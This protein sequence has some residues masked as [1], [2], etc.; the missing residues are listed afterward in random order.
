MESQFIRR[1]FM[2]KRVLACTLAM[3]LA[4]QPVSAY[5]HSNEQSRQ[6]TIAKKLVK[7]AQRKANTGAIQ[8][9]VK[10]STLNIPLEKAGLYVKVQK[11]GNEEQIKNIDETVQILKEEN[12]VQT[13]SLLFDNLEA[14][15]YTVIV[16]DAK[17]ENG[18]TS[19]RFERYM[20]TLTVESDILN[21]IQ[22]VDTH[23]SNGIFEKAT[24]Q[25]GTIG[26]GDF[27]Q[28]DIIDE[29][30][31]EALIKAI[32][33]AEKGTKEAGD[34]IYDLNQDD[35][36]DLV[37]LQ[38]F[39]YSSGENL[40]STVEKTALLDASNVVVNGDNTKFLA[41][42]GTELSGDTLID[43]L[44]SSET[45]VQLQPK[46]EGVISEKNPVELDME[47]LS[48]VKTE[49]IT[50]S[51]PEDNAIAGG[52]IFVTV[53]GEENPIEL[54]IV[55]ET[56]SVKRLQSVKAQTKTAIVKED[57][58]IVINLGK[59]V[60]IKRVVIRV[61]ATTNPDA[62]LAEISQVTFVN[63]MES[64]IPQPE[65]D[66]PT[67]LKAT[68][69]HQQIQLSWEKQTNVMGYEIKI[70]EKGKPATA[71]IQSSTT[72]SYTIKSF[73]NGK[74]GKLE[75]GKQYEIRVRSVNGEWRSA[76]SD[77]IEVSPVVGQKPDKPEGVSI[78]S[79][80]GQLSISWK[81]MDD[82]DFYTLYYREAG[83]EQYKKI[84]SIVGTSYTLKDLKQLAT[85][86]IYLTG[87]NVIGTSDPSQMYKGKTVDE[88][89]PETTEY[90]L[91]NTSNGEGKPSNHI[92][93][94]TYIGGI[95]PTDKFAIVDNLYSTGWRVDDWTA[96]V[97][98]P[99]NKPPIVTFDQKYTMDHLILIPAADQ[100]SSYDTKYYQSKVAYIDDNGKEVVVPGEFYQSRDKNGKVYY[101]FWSDEP[102]TADKVK[103]G[104]DSYVRKITYN[105]LRFY[106][107]DDI[108]EKIEALFTDATMVTLKDTVTAEDI[109]SLKDYLNT[110]D[111]KSGDYHPKKNI[112]LK[113]LDEAE[114][115]LN[116][117][118]IKP[119]LK[120]NTKLT[121]A[122]DSAVKFSRSL[123]T[124]QP[125]G[126]IAR[127]GEEISITVGR[128]GKTIGDSSEVK[129]VI[130][131]YN[132][133]V[134]AWQRT[135]ISNLKVGNNT[136]KIS[137]IDN[138][139]KEQGGNLYIE[140]TGKDTSAEISVRVL[141]GQEVPVLDL[142]DI[143]DTEKRKDKIKTYVEQLEAYAKSIEEIHTKQHEGAVDSSYDFTYDP[144][145]CILQGTDIGTDYVMFSVPTV[146][147]LKGLDAQIT[148]EGKTVS[149]ETRA[150]ALERILTS[151]D[152]M[153]TLFY[154]HKGLSKDVAVG[155]KNRVPSNRL[156][157]RYMT[158]F[159]GAFMY[160]ASGHIGIGYDSVQGLFSLEEFKTTE[161]GQYVSGNLFGWGIAHEIGHV[162]NQGSYEV[163]EVTNNFYSQLAQSQDNNESY[164]MKYED[165]YKD[166]TSGTKGTKETNLTMYWQLHLAYD[167][168][169]NYMTY[170]TQK[171][172]FDHF[173]YARVDT[174]DRNPAQA[175]ADALAQNIVTKENQVKLTLNSDANNN[176]MRLASA[177]AK[178]NLSD[179]FEAWGLEPNEETKAYMSQYPK[180]TRK[181]QYID[182][183]SKAFRV[184]NQ[185][186]E[187]Q[188]AE[189][190]KA[191]TVKAEIENPD[192]ESRSEVK[193]KIT[194]DS[195]ATDEILGYEII[196]NG[197]TVGFVAASDGETVFVD[198]VQTVN[199]RV[200]NYEVIA[201]DRLLNTTQTA[202]LQPIKIKNENVF[203]D[204]TNWT[205]TTNMHSEQDTEVDKNDQHPDS[206]P[207]SG[208]GNLDQTEVKSAL[209]AII[210]DITTAESYVGTTQEENA[211]M[212][213]NFNE[214]ISI[215][216]VQ[217]RLKDGSDETNAL[218]EFKFYV[219]EDGL[220]WGE[221][222]K[223]GTLE[224]KDRIASTYFNKEDDDKLYVYDT[225]YLKIEAVGQQ[226]LSIAELDVLAPAGDNVEIDAI[227][228][229]KEDYMYAENAV[230]SGGAL[231]FT[232]EYK[233]NPAYNVVLLRDKDNQII[234]GEQIIL[235][236]TPVD[237]QLGNIESGRW[238][239][240]IDD[241]EYIEQLK[242]KEI[243][244]ELY[245][246]DDALT[247]AGERLVSDTFYVKVPEEL[248]EITLHSDLDNK[249]EPTE[250]EIISD[251]S[252][253]EDSSEE[254]DQQEESVEIEGQL[255]L[256]SQTQVE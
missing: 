88:S 19:S 106:E 144:E 181:I 222:I 207:V 187:A 30:D 205:V 198:P 184:A 43:A 70:Q 20:Q 171:E 41:E 7:T 199:N 23:V 132:A 107:H 158:M 182:D 196:R 49:G 223:E 136:V 140:Y 99:N 103:I 217:V 80:V 33:R 239:F 61:T 31:E 8:V 213:V 4:L 16:D 232:G 111:E 167:T 210:F 117:K 58:S 46:A 152:K 178:K 227:G 161:D 11:A 15:D 114:R 250:E 149:T 118:D 73:K 119:A 125:L 160:A 246:V 195:K 176:F 135:L 159:A 14:G 143:T 101:E 236:P 238:I 200:F 25:M 59:Q 242:G 90:K 172:M 63:D 175:D 127:E 256:E 248:P 37:D 189:R 128:S 50:I 249:Q 94:V 91:I 168:V 55:K 214:N 76:Y 193:I 177:A 203:L 22:I 113:I 148:R 129:L 29:K 229:L 77:A 211:T 162:I 209:G 3:C 95:H 122:N 81:E 18:K 1:S 2:I 139:A 60:A 221:P 121:T 74:K 197:V 218:K 240:F 120:V 247:N 225:S 108:E 166:V 21:A 219:S 228:T 85:Y 13:A 130:A 47:I 26:Y 174:Y 124:W 173:F 226:S 133:E 190:T 65:L 53:E 165:V 155:N 204:K 235:A 62:K 28:D 251:S 220:N 137:N 5:A 153:V 52:S 255:M 6:K 86:E 75:N 233:G 39:A 92:T 93:D 100:P 45:S 38:Y 67:K 186:N 230:I 57:G 252:Q 72:T 191:T 147:V 9:V 183:D 169:Y 243:K 208:T 244:V 27:N 71:E 123:N 141:G 17:E 163:A 24:Q 212:I 10:F 201:Y 216:G 179:F 12:G 56:K 64:K 66:I 245:R 112:L 40:Q 224:Y 180:E 105:E 96:D 241:K 215:A 82:T 36:V 194:N 154:N 231:V 48:D 104:V 44:L 109:Q 150:D 234:G 146:E 115:I 83:T 164:R 42:D 206:A 237:G 78:Q 192:A 185:G 89:L 188:I 131:Q 202:V 98:Y 170:E 84:E 134:N 156:N 116:N 142:K 145:N 35:K 34:T 69:G 126:V 51:T 157:I 110:P 32:Q 253:K 54:T 151:A 102:F 79:G 97:S 68:A 254:M 87:T 138:L